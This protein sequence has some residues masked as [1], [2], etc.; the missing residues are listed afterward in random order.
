MLITALR[1]AQNLAHALE[2]RALGAVPQRTY[3]RQL[4]MAKRDWALILVAMALT[5]MLLLAR[6]VYGFGLDTLR[7]LP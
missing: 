5:A 6:F 2:S 1:M 3:M 4:H 7:L